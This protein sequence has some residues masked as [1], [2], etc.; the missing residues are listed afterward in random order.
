MRLGDGGLFVW[1]PIALTAGLKAEV[2]AL[3]EP[4]FVVAPNK[5][6]HLH[7]AEW[8]AAYPQAKLIAPP[9]LRRRRS[10][11]AFD[12]DLM[13]A[14]DPDWA[15]DI[16]QVLF[17]GSFAV[18]EAVFFHRAS[19]TAIFA[20]LIQSLPRDLVKGWRRDLARLGGILEP[21]YGIPG[22]WRASF[23]N[24]TAARAALARILAW[25]I[26]R[27][28][29]AHGAPAEHD[30]KAFVRRAFTWLAK[31]GSDEKNQHRRQQRS[32]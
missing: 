26:E 13:D 23:L 9:G 1:S 27:V 21:T 12:A 2:D 32:M 6:H 4:G 25:D 14:P 17:A 24:R 31:P 3:G 30:G 28:V 10:D 11:L 8:K 15:G 16:D 18:T 20:D 7:L 29:I 19:R 5:L 22:D